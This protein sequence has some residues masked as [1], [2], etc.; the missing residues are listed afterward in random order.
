M[1]WYRW[2]E[3]GTIK[4]FITSSEC[5]P[6][7]IMNIWDRGYGGGQYKALSVRRYK[8]ISDAHRELGDDLLPPQVDVKEMKFRENLYYIEF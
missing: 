8:T 1:M 7:D 2:I 5:K 6:G 3:S 4:Y